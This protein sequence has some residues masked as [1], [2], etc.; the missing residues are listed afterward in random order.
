MSTLKVNKIEDLTGNTVLSSTGTKWNLHQGFG[1]NTDSITASTD[2]STPKITSLA[3]LE[4]D[5]STGIINMP[6]GNK[7]KGYDLGSIIAP[8][9]LLQKKVA[10]WTNLYTIIYPTVD[11]ET[12]A[13]LSEG[14]YSDGGNH[15]RVTITPL[16]AT[17]K[18]HLTI[19]LNA[20]W[21]NTNVLFHFA[22]YDITNTT[23]V[24]PLGSG[25][26]GRRPVHF[27]YRAQAAYD[28]NDMGQMR[29]SL[30]TDANNLTTRTYALH[31][32]AEAGNTTYVN[33]SS[34]SSANWSGT[35]ISLMSAEEIAV[36]QQ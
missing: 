17:S 6:T 18:I 33:H 27:A 35:W 2:V 12:T 32:W 36:E 1:L 29:F 4:A 15:H 28:S 34:S 13:D 20:N 21:T 8:G 7:F 26:S 31:G 14:T 23:Y 22:F 11:T 24:A 19:E 25:S 9:M 16:V 5:T 3:T 30:Y 10:Q